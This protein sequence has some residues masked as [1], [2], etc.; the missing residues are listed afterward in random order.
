MDRLKELKMILIEKQ[1][2][3]E[4]LHEKSEELRTEIAILNDE[5]KLANTK[6]IKQFNKKVVERVTTESSSNRVT[7]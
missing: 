1:D 7:K 3:L 5:W 2:K 6:S 4:D